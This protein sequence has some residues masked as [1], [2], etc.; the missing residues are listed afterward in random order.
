[1]VSWIWILSDV[2]E[3]DSGSQRPKSIAV[4]N[5]HIAEYIYDISLT[6]NC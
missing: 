1:M 4:R 3:E 2:K 6:D 5:A